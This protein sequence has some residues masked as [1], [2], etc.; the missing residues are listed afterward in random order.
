M[1]QETIQNDLYWKWC[2]TLFNGTRFTQRHS[3]LMYALAINVYRANLYEVNKITG[4]KKL[5]RKVWN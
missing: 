3:N 1:K 2:G 4:K 5:I